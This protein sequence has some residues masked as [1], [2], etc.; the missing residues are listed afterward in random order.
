MNILLNLEKL[1]SYC[2]YY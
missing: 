2:Y 1:S